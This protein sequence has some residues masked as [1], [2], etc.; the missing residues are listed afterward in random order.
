MDGSLTNIL[1]SIK[2]RQIAHMLA[3]SYVCHVKSIPSVNNTFKLRYATILKTNM[4]EFNNKLVHILYLY[5]NE[6]FWMSFSF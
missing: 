2:F 1:V 5:A 6:E 3:F 4:S